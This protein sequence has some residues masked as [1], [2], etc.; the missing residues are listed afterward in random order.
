MV[1]I[2]RRGFDARASTGASLSRDP[3]VGP[4][5]EEQGTGRIDES[6]VRVIDD[7]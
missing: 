2:P 1:R 6:L 7:R 4:R 3:C 5:A